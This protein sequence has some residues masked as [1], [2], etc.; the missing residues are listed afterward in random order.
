[1]RDICFTFDRFADYLSQYFSRHTAAPFL[2]VYPVIRRFRFSSFILQ[3]HISVLGVYIFCRLLLYPALRSPSDTAV[4]RRLYFSPHIADLSRMSREC[5]LKY[6]RISAENSS[7]FLRNRADGIFC[8]F[9]RAAAL[10]F[11][12]ISR[13]YASSKNAATEYKNRLKAIRRKLSREV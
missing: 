7:D 5:I 6:F 4:I 3:S 9:R 2:V 13:E 1:V 12:K 11:S 10:F 8:R